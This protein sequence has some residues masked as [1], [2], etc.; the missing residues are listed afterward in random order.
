[1]ASLAA[2][3]TGC[4]DRRRNDDIDL[5]RRK[6][7]RELAQS[8]RISP[9]GSFFDHDVLAFDI[10]ERG[11]ALAKRRTILQSHRS[12][13]RAE[14]KDA[15]ARNLRRGLAAAEPGR[16][17]HADGPCQENTAARDHCSP[18]RERS[19]AIVRLQREMSAAN[20]RLLVAGLRQLRLSF[21]L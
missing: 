7:A 19:P 17:E 18:C 10:A 16:S 1:M 21:H 14:P 20:D 11:E 2:R 13:H 15:D 12:V 3:G 8:L 6:F 4:G 5:A 9:C